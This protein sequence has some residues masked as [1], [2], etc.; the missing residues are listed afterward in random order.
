MIVTEV[1]DPHGKARVHDDEVGEEA[2]CVL[3][4]GETGEAA[5]VLTDQTD[6]LQSKMIQ[7]LPQDEAVQLVGVIVRAGVLVRLA[8]PYNGQS[9]LSS[10]CPA[11]WCVCV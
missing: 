8:K 4:H 11:L 5:P 9:Q 6:L 10:F 7:Q 1:Q 3:D 2:R